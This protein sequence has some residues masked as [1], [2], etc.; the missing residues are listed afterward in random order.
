MPNPLP[1]PN[2]VHDSPSLLPTKRGTVNAQLRT[3]GGISDAARQ[4]LGRT[5]AAEA[6]KRDSALLQHRL[7]GQPRR[8]EF[9]YHAARRGMGIL[10]SSGSVSVVVGSRRMNCC[11][12][13]VSILSSC[14]A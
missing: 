13:A 2:D 12:M 3:Q 11:G 9:K 10:P 7:N 5:A 6:R 4:A 8:N 1:G 14:G